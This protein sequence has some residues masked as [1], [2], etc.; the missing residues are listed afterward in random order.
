[1]FNSNCLQTH[2]RMDSHMPRHITIA[3]NRRVK[4]QS[5]F[6]LNYEKHNTGFGK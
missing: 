6:T 2:G 1:V 5:R 4:L 3:K